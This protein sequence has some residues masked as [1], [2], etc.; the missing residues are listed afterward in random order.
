MAKKKQS[1][2]WVDPRNIR[3]AGWHPPKMTEKGYS[4]LFDA[5]EGGQKKIIVSG[6]LSNLYG[7]ALMA[8]QCHLFYTD[9]LSPSIFLGKYWSPWHSSGEMSTIIRALLPHVEA[10]IQEYC[11]VWLTQI[12][13]L[14]EL[15]QEWA[16]A[17]AKFF[18]LLI[19]KNDEDFQVLR[20]QVEL[21]RKENGASWVNLPEFQPLVSQLDFAVIKMQQLIPRL[22]ELIQTMHSQFSPDDLQALAGNQQVKDQIEAS[23]DE[24]SHKRAINK[25]NQIL[26]RSTTEIQSSEIYM[27]LGFRYAELGEIPQ[28]IENYTKSLDLAKLPNPLIYFWRGELYYRQKVWDKAIKDFEQALALEIYTPEREQ[29]IQYI[30]ELQSK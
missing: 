3:P 30:S 4:R 15:N 19:P 2:S 13:V 26:K 21:Y 16:N 18:N 14:D 9:N 28:A 22:D 10:D 25:L 27:E 5:F 23:R 29:A 17:L 6:H 20:N 7:A 12:Q 11:E 1:K 8:Y 24:P